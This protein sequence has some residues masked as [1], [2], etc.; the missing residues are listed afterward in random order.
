MKQEYR[1]KLNKVRAWIKEI[2]YLAA[3]S[4]SD[5]ELE[6][7]SILHYGLIEELAK[8]KDPEVLLELFDFYTNENG[9]LGGFDETLKEAI[10]D[11][12]TLEQILRALSEKFDSFCE[13]SPD[14]C[15][16]VSNWLLNEGLF[17]TIRRLF[18]FYKPRR[19]QEFLQEL[20]ILSED[21]EPG[22]NHCDAIA[23]LREDMKHW[24]KEQA[25]AQV[26]ALKG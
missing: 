7:D 18:N 21:D 10:T 2:P 13:T 14:W 8:S 1:D 26:P 6:Q 12:Y 20:S 23:I 4:L 25:P 17:D 5:E 15:A 3:S 16:T 9:C 24:P 11:N 22:Y 19:S